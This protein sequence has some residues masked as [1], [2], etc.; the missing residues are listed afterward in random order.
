[1]CMKC[2]FCFADVEETMIFCPACG[3]KLSGEEVLEEAPEQKQEKKKSRVGKYILGAVSVV[4]LALV[5]TVGILYSMG[6][7][8]TAV[9]KIENAI[10]SLKF[11]RENDIYYHLT[12]SANAEKLEKQ[13]TVVVATVGDQKLTNGELQAYYW[14][15][16]YDATSYNT[17]PNLDTKKALSQQVYDN[18]TGKTYEQLFL[19]TALNNWR[20]YATLIQL[21]K[22]NNFVMDADQKAYYDNIP[23]R[24][25]E[26][27]K[28]YGYDDLGKF[29]KEQF[30]PGCSATAY[31]SYNST[32]YL[33]LTYYDVLLSG[34][35]PTQDEINSYYTEHEDEIVK[36]GVNKDS[37]NYYN[38]RHILIAP[39][40]GATSGKYTDADWESWRVKA[41]GVLDNFLA[42]EATEAKFAELAN[43]LSADTAI[44]GGLYSNLTKSTNFV[45]EFK[46]WYLDETRKPGDTGIVKSA[47]GYHIMYF[48][49]SRPIWEHETETMMLTEKTDAALKAAEDK[50]A[51]TVDYKQI[52]VSEINLTA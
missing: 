32:T 8:D 18:K 37:G 9:G 25:S 6:M 44:S 17:Y 48:S 1:M 49:G 39:E 42:G 41:H 52:K 43:E 36:S 7:M 20:R 47:H 46:A 35:V 34:M 29:L 26:M 33:A 23:N 13:D 10:H 12:Y 28:E 45:E 11:N 3:K 21:S 22:E 5:L 24:I 2:K 40:G 51:M 16:I 19:E 38:V 4:V 27:A 15:A 50:W 31:V 14:S 30:V